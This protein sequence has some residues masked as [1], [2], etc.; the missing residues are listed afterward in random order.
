MRLVGILCVTGLLALAGCAPPEVVVPPPADESVAPSAGGG[1][2][3]SAAPVGNDGAPP[4]GNASA[5]DRGLVD[6]PGDRGGL[7]KEDMVNIRAAMLCADKRTA[8]DE[9]ARAQAHAEILAQ[10]GAQQKF[11]DQVMKDITEE[12]ELAK[13][14]DAKVAAKA[15]ELCPE[16]GAPPAK[17]D[18][19]PADADAAPAEGEAAPAGDEAAP[20][21]EGD[22][23]TPAD[24]GE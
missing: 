1:A 9:A 3:A 11:L 2:E 24:G 17:E 10:H 18:A 21:A 5:S 8:G 16:G 20:A 6:G 23:A 19:A 12:P 4:E 14:L 13:Q 22:A 7:G 15:E